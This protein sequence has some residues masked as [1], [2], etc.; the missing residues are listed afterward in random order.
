MDGGRDGGG[1]ARAPGGAGAPGELAG[2][3]VEGGDAGAAGHAE[4]DDEPVALDER[5]GGDAEK[6]LLEPEL[7]EEF[8]APEHLARVQIEAVEAALG[9]EG[10]DAAG[11]DDGTGARTRIEAVAVAVGARIGELP[12]T[13]AVAGAQAV[14]D[15]VVADAV[16]QHEP[17]ARDG[18]GGEALAFLDF[19]DGAKAVP[20][21]L[22][23]QRRLGRNHVV[24]RT[25]ERRP[26]RGGGPRGER[27]GRGMEG[28]VGVVLRGG[29]GALAPQGDD[30]RGGVG[31]FRA[32]P[33][34]RVRGAE[35]DGGDEQA[36]DGGQGEFH[37]SVGGRPRRGG[38]FSTASAKS[39][40]CPVM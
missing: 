37:G 15:L 38:Y 29:G 1:V 18:G 22:L 30:G 31:K 19:P 5:G 13:L 17:V 39:W 32:R 28:H 23:E 16:K 2:A 40:V 3:G 26:V 35:R 21:E 9:A 12:E 8:T 14:D 20:G 25:E 10:E 4:I 27:L 24:R 36:E 7:S 34:G 6:I 33:G 11:G